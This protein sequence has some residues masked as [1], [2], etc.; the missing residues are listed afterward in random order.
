M[1][2]FLLQTLAAIEACHGF[3]LHSAYLR[4]YHNVVADALTRQDAPKVMEEAGLARMPDPTRDLERFLDRGWQRRALVWAGQPEADRCQALRLAEERRGGVDLPAQPT[5][6]ATHLTFLDSSNLPRHYA[7]AFLTHGADSD[8]ERPQLL[9]V[10]IAGKEAGVKLRDFLQEVLSRR[11]PLVWADSRDEKPMADLAKGFRKA[12]YQVEVHPLCGRTLKDQVWWK[13]WVLVAARGQLQPFAWRTADAE[14]IT[15]PLSGYPME[16]RI[17]DSKVPKDDWE[18]GILKVDPTMP[19]FGATKPKPAGTLTAPGRPRA[20]VWDPNRPLPGLHDGSWVAERDDRLLLLGK[21]PDGPAA[22]TVTA[23]EAAKLLHGRGSYYLDDGQKAAGLEPQ[24]L[25]AAAPRRL[26]NLAV[27]WAIEQTPNGPDPEKVGV[28]RLKWEEE[29]ERVLMQWLRDNPKQMSPALVGGERPGKGRNK[30][31]PR[32][33]RAMKA[34]CYVLRHAAGTEECPISEE[35]WVRWQQMAE[36]ESCRRFQNW[37]LL[38]ALEKDQKDRLIAKQDQEHVWWIAAWSGHTQDRVVGPA[39]L[40]PDSE[41][42]SLLV[43]GSYRR[44]TA[45]IQKWGLARRDR[46]VHFHD[47]EE[48]TERWRV[49]LETRVDVDVKKAV[50][51]GCH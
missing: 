44:H 28:C 29:T 16:W 41:L 6:S 31:L 7:A 48:H 51:L 27:R 50:S 42:P 39:A 45:S 1:A 35:G 12:G 46:D 33:E 2:S 32:H 17:E 47:P 20:L 3:F 34:M 36:H 18:V 23:S 14:P 10:S 11:P 9:C 26:A 49:D 4:T 38:E 8:T 15:P 37:E 25:L 24:A 30:G 13:R 43:H 22:R 5:S 21:G 19:F 40:V